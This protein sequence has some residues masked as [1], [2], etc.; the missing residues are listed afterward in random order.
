MVADREYLCLSDEKC[1]PLGKIDTNTE[2]RQRGSIHFFV[3][4]KVSTEWVQGIYVASFGAQC[5]LDGLF[6]LRPPPFYF[7]AVLFCFVFVL[8]NNTLCCYVQ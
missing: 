5:K 8:C 7:H 2:R 6:S 4:Q 1:E 3:Q